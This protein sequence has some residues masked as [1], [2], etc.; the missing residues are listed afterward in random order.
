M[1]W[2]ERRLTGDGS[3]YLVEMPVV[4]R[5]ERPCSSAVGLGGLLAWL[6]NRGWLKPPT[7]EGGVDFK[8]E[9]NATRLRG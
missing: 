7:P 1:D 2:E 3:P 5:D 9:A 4:G 8:S 6:G